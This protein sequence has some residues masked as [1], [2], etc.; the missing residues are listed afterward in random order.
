MPAPAVGAYENDAYWGQ[1][2][3]CFRGYDYEDV[4]VSSDFSSDG[5]VVQMQTGTAGKGIHVV[6]MGDGFSDRQIADG[7]YGNVMRRA[8]DAFFEEE[9]YRSFKDCF[10]ISYVNAVSYTEGYDH[11]GQALGTFFG[12]G[13]FVDGDREKV[14]DYALKVIPESELDQTVIIVLMNKDAYAGSCTMYR[15]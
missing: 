2:S 3:G 13:T 1:Y 10:D 14:I 9:P 6:L 4:Y 12:E 5:T 8:M 15:S 11:E 7:M